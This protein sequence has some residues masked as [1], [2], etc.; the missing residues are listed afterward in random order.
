M[1]P[2]QLASPSDA[3]DSDRKARRPLLPTVSRLLTI[4]LLLAATISFVALTLNMVPSCT[5][6]IRQDPLLPALGTVF[7]G[8]LAALSTRKFARPWLSYP[9]TIATVIHGALVHVMYRSGVS[10]W[11]C[12]GIAIVCLLSLCLCL[13]L[14]PK[15]ILAVVLLGPIA[16]GAAFGSSFQRD[17][18]LLTHSRPSRGAVRLFLYERAGCP[19][20]AQFKETVLPKIAETFGAS[21]EILFVGAERLPRGFDT[22]P[23]IVIATSHKIEIVEAPVTAEALIKKI[24]KLLELSTGVSGRV[25]TSH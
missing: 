7:Y 24:R 6:C 21:I 14:F 2:Y 12:F 23:Q 13:V 1:I 11:L 17:S 19:A 5:A 4:S 10:C 9:I 15:G 18:W 8:A 3:D 22:I 20:C 16:A 25:K